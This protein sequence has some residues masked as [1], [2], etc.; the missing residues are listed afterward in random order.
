MNADE[1]IAKLGLKPHPEG[2]YYGETF[3]DEPGPDGRSRVTAIHFLLKAGERSHWHKVDAA[4]LWF[5]HGGG[6][7]KLSIAHSGTTE[8]ITLGADLFAGQTPH[9]IVPPGAW[10]AA[11]PLGDYA[12]VSCAVAPG[13]EFSGFVLAPP[14]W[15]P[16]TPG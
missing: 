8:H 5:W 11:E 2:G 15:E 4:E 7:L 16:G 6:P 9:G 12:L 1:I 13:F 3:R 10:Q 14:D